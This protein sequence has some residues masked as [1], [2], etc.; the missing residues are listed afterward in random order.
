[1]LPRLLGVV[2]LDRIG[3]VILEISAEPGKPVEQPVVDRNREDHAIGAVRS[4]HVL[5]GQ[6]LLS[7]PHMISGCR[8]SST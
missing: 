7:T 8:R 5:D 4:E 3:L 6:D 2:G 1:V